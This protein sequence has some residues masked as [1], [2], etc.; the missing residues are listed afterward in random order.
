MPCNWTQN[1]HASDTLSAYASSVSG[2]V[3]MGTRS[4]TLS[5]PP[6]KGCGAT[7]VGRG[8]PKKGLWGP[9]PW[10]NR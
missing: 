1:P 3:S 6:Y 4:F 10:L 8:H 9:F 2:R 5:P 7:Q